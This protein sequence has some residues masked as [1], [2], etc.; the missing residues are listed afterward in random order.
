MTSIHVPVPPGFPIGTKDSANTLARWES[1]LPGK[2]PCGITSAGMELPHVYRKP[3]AKVELRGGEQGIVGSKE[4][5]FG[6]ATYVCMYIIVYI[7]VY[8]LDM[9][10][11]VYRHVIHI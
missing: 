8:R 7:D 11:Y 4:D 2:T 10:M 6:V 5:H 3:V 1:F 9:Y